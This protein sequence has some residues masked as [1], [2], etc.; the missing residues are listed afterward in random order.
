MSAIVRCGSCRQ[1]NRVD[2]NRGALARCGRCGLPIPGSFAAAVD[3]VIKEAD[4]SIERLG[5][6]L[7]GF[8]GGRPGGPAN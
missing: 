5:K 2:P 6:A 3:A 7:R 8:W 4:S 1:L